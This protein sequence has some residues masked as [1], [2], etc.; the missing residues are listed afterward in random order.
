MLLC[1]RAIANKALAPFI[2]Y[3]APW[4][5]ITRRVKVPE[6]KRTWIDHV[7]A[8]CVLA[9][10]GPPRRFNRSAHGDALERV[11]KAAVRKLALAHRVVR[12]VARSAV[13]ELHNHI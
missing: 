2:E 4:V 11:Q 13:E 3:V 7:R 8:R 1:G 10:K 5:T 12:V 6:L 9:T